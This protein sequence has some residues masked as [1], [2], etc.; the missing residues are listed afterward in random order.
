[1]FGYGTYFADKAK[2]SIGYSSFRG[3]YWASGNQDV[4]YLA[5]YNV[6]LGNW[7]HVLGRN[8]QYSRHQS[9]MTSLDYKKLRSYGDYD[10][11]FAEGGADLMNNEYT[12]YEENQS[13][14]SYLV[15]IK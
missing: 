14:I 6:H 13:T 7:F 1:M 4:A 3:S 10:S 5:L 12:V 11:L 9:W 8:C 15:E 2:K